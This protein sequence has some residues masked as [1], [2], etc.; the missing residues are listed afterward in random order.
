[1]TDNEKIKECKKLLESAFNG[2]NRLTI[3]GIS[4]CAVISTIADCLSKAYNIIGNIEVEEGN[5]GS[6]EDKGK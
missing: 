4:G 5:A 1:M 2:L 3:S 6:T